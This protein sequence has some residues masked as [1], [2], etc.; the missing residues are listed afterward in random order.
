MEAGWVEETA[1]QR[2]WRSLLNTRLDQ[3]LSDKENLRSLRYNWKHFTNLKE[4]LK[5]VLEERGLSL[6]GLVAKAFDETW[7]SEDEQ[8]H[9]GAK[10]SS[11]VKV[12]KTPSDHAVSLGPAR[13]IGVRQGQIQG[14]VLQAGDD[15]R[16]KQLQKRR[17][18]EARLRR[19]AQG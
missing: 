6:E 13:E 9:N 15:C 11:P 12:K 4:K 7:D 8:K 1:H 18:I 19:F 5:L 17:C 10:K 2:F 16:E 14:H 3:L